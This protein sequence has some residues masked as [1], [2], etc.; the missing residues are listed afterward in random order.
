[1]K[2]NPKPVLAVGALLVAQACA[3][4]RPTEVPAQM[5]RTE[6]VLQQAERSGA[7]AE[8]L[9][10][11]QGAR[12]KYLEA[13]RL[14]EKKSEKADADAVRLAKQAEVDAQY[15][16]AK[17]QAQRQ[18]R[19]ADDGEQSVQ[20]LDSEAQRNVATPAPAGAGDQN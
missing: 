11:F 5:A 1:M 10:E 4:H 18:Q 20:Q 19:S 16:V 2:T 17:T 3:Y 12:D 7:Q 6:A 15:A 8:S 14:L 13:Q 9:P